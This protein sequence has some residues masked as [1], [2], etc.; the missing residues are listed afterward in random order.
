MCALE[1][2]A[3]LSFVGVENSGR[4]PPSRARKFDREAQMNVTSWSRLVP[5][6]ATAQEQPLVDPQVVHFMQV[7]LRTSV[8]LPHSPQASPS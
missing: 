4:V 2:A 8:K 3:A 7:P 5:I 6:L 1:L